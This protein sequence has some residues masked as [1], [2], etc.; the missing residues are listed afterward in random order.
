MPIVNIYVYTSTWEVSAHYI[1]TA[2][3]A[4]RVQCVWFTLSDSPI[5]TVTY[6]EPYVC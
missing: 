5:R 3:F 1:A 2:C 4:L 6:S